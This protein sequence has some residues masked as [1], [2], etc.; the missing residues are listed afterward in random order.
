MQANTKVSVL[1]SVYIKEKP[2]YLK[3]AMDSIIN[4][5]RKADEILV[6]EDGPLTDELYEMIKG[7]QEEHPEIRTYIFEENVQLGR[8]L[9]KGV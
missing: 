5:T 4:Q 6:M 1:M 8:A 2:E 3:A 9:A 7:Y